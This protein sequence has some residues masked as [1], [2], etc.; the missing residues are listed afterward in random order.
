VS[1]EMNPTYEYPNPGTYTVTLTTENEC[2]E[3]VSTSTVNI[4]TAISAVF[5]SNFTT[6]CSPSIINFTDESSTGTSSW[7]WSFPGGTPAASTEQNPTIVYDEVGTYPVSLEVS[8]GQGSSDE[9]FLEDYITIV[10]APV[11]AFDYI[12]EGQKVTFINNSENG[13]SYEWD[14][15]DGYPNSFEENPVHHYWQTG[16]YEIVLF[17]SNG[18]CGSIIAQEV[19]LIISNTH[20][21]NAN[22]QV[23]L[24]PNPVQDVFQIQFSEMVNEDLMIRLF[25]SK[26]QL[27]QQQN[28][29][30]ITDMEL[31]FFDYP[32]GLYF[33]QIVGDNINLTERI[34]KE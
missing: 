8:N 15:G 30:G 28:I 22:L 33:L 6:A 29:K 18:Y 24:F 27:I 7:N 25:S 31:N 5:T 21:L 17:V 12:Q 10:P 13:T 26:G 11:A 1:T 2:G 19:E 3:E 4:E 32:K 9:L 16:I 14:F 23:D 20:E 34:L